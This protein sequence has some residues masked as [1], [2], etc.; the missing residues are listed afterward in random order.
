MC[1]YNNNLFEIFIL[2]YNNFSST[3]QLCLDSLN[4]QCQNNSIKVSVLDN[5]SSDNSADLLKKYSIQNSIITFYSHH[6]LGFAGGMNKITK[7]SKS[8]WLVLL[9]SDTIVSP[10]FVDKL[11]LYLPK[12]ANDFGLVGPVSNNAG[13]CQKLFYEKLN[14]SEYFDLHSNLINNLP[15]L[16]FEIPRLDFF[17]VFIRRKVWEKLNGLCLDY[18]QGYY[19]D[20]DFCV[21][22]NFAGYKCGVI[23]NIFVYHYGSAS[24]KKVI[25]QSSLIKNNKKIFISKFPKVSLL[26][27]RNDYLFLLRK[28]LNNSVFF[29][30]YSIIR[31]VNFRINNLKFLFPKS[32][33]KLI[34]FYLEIFYLRFL[35]YR[36]ISKI[37]S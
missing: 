31:L 36:L 20:F 21:R 27:P 12:V 24:F 5:F 10:D 35:F 9:G 34:K 13:T 25:S 18:G 4:K 26:H 22:A 23:E 16:C 33:L 29:Q 8:D 15:F 2:G 1:S 14:V 6:N 11:F 17:C 37:N 28:Y 3:T 32:P 30:S 7:D 19:E